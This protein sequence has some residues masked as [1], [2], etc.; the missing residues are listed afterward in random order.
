MQQVR[1]GRLIPAVSLTMPDD[2]H[3]R[4]HRLDGTRLLSAAKWALPAFFILAAVKCWLWHR[5]A[6]AVTGSEKNGEICAA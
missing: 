2:A 1:V 4:R 5:S 3:L 6:S